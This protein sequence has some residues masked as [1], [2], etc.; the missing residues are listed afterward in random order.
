MSKKTIL[1]A[2]I[3]VS[4][5]LAACGA[6]GSNTAPMEEPLPMGVA[7]ER[8]ADMDEAASPSDG[9]SFGGDAAQIEPLVI[10]TANLSLVVE[11]PAASADEIGKMAEEMGG[12]VVFS[13]V[14]QTSFDST[15]NVVTRASVTIRVPSERLDEAL[16]QIEEGA[17][18][19]QNRSVQGEDV[20]QQYT[21]LQSRLR[22][23][24]VAEEQ[25]RQI[26]E[27]A[28]ETEDVLQVFENLRQV[29]EQIEVLQGQIN[30]FEDSARLSSIS[31]ELIP[32]VLAQPL[33]IGGW[34][35]EGTAKEALET[36]IRTL[37]TIVDAG[38]WVLICVVPIGL[39]LGLPG[40]FALRSYL[41]RRKQEKTEEAQE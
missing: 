22:N 39:L 26:M 27:D 16:D 33:Q 3:L 8:V 31:I 41:R 21:D 5:V 18:E 23:L 19:V 24:E 13:N 29:R 1:S 11:D 37:Q 25:L 40:Y 4:F 36:L 38:I 34:R 10:R 12:F 32:D 20:T 9:R 30:Y 17:I 35:P 2:L 14:F 15:S 7:L 28:I 6:A